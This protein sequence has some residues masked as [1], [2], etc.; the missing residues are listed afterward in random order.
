MYRLTSRSARAVFDSQKQRRME[1]V[2]RC[3]VFERERSGDQL[4][5]LDA[6]HTLC[7]R[8]GP[9]QATG[10]NYLVECFAIN[11]HRETVQGFCATRRKLR[12]HY[13]KKWNSIF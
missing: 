4:L 6:M 10:P 11:P 12:G 5:T 2:R 8:S 9:P 1:K 3:V 7:V 13:P